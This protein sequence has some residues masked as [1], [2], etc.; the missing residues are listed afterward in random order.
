MRKTVGV[1][2]SL[3]LVSGF[4]AGQSAQVEPSPGLVKADSPIHGL[5]VMF[6]NALAMTPLSDPGRVAYE[7]ASEVVVAYERNNTEAA[8]KALENLNQTVSEAD[9]R[10]A[11][12]L[13]KAEAVLQNV[14][15][16]VPEEATQGI[17]TALSRIGEARERVRESFTGGPAD[18]Q[19]KG[20]LPDFGGPPG[21]PSNPE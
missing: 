10:H 12:G 11:Q 4:V 8:S 2:L 13:E 14:N 15:E 9:Q 21:R 1:A 5:D 20:F 18:N 7:R 6:D 3:I 19:S 16:T 17:E